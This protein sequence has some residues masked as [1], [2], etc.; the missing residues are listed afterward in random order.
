LLLFVKFVVIFS[1]YFFFFKYF[2]LISTSIFAII[3][4]PELIDKLD[5]FRQISQ[6]RLTR[7]LDSIGGPKDLIIESSVMKP[8]ERF[9]G[10]KVLK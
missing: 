6:T 9:I 8:M 7:V 2:K 5:A 4:V 10:V 3:M 1:L